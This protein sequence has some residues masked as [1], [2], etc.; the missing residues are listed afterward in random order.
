[1]CGTSYDNGG[2]NH[3]VRKA[4]HIDTLTANIVSITT[5]Q[6]NNV[7]LNTAIDLANIKL[8][9]E[10]DPATALDWYT[11]II[12]VNYTTGISNENKQ[13]LNYAYGRMW[14]ALNNGIGIGSISFSPTGEPSAL[15]N[16]VLSC[17]HK[18]IA[19]QT[20]YTDNQYKYAAKYN[21]EIDRITPYGVPVR[22]YQTALDTLSTMYSWI[23]NDNRDELDFYQCLMQKELERI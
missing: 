4:L 19:F 16:K 2:T 21:Y 6:F 10:N 20:G 14:D 9:I 5:T 18:Q 1:M 23:Q 22:R 12:L 17:I 13:L 3:K 11:Q 15:F 8:F 7:K